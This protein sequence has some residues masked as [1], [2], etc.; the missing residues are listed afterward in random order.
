MNTDPRS[1]QSQEWKE[2]LNTPTAKVI[3]TLQKI[4]KQAGFITEEDV[5]VLRQNIRNPSMPVVIRPGK[6]PRFSC[7][8]NELEYHMDQVNRNDDHVRDVF[9]E[10]S[11]PVEWTQLGYRPPSLSYD[12]VVK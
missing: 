3:C 7:P 2:T 11:T 8:L 9:I 6:A 1:L 4:A 5:L 10:F 12:R